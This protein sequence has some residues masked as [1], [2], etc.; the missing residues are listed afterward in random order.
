MQKSFWQNS[1]FI[2]DKNSQE[3]GYRGNIPQ[4]N[5]VHILQT[6][7]QHYT[8]WWKAERISS[9]I[10]NKTRITTLATSLHSIENPSHSNQTRKINKRN[11]NWKGRSKTV[12]VC[13]WYNTTYGNPK[14]ATKK[15]LELTNEFSKVEGYKINIQKLVAFL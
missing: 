7:S 2:S 6:Y 8:Q 1:T 3:S 14:D 13:R 12:T 10:K 4:H 11:P 15:L 9:K 5:K